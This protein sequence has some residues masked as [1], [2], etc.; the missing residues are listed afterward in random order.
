MN[1]SFFIEEHP[2][3]IDL[4]LAL[5]EMEELRQHIERYRREQDR[6]LSAAAWKLLFRVL[7]DE[8]GIDRRPNVRFT[9]LGKPLVDSTEG[10][11]I[12]LSHC[13][14]AV[15]CAV[16]PVPV[17][18]D[19]EST[20]AYDPQLLPLTMNVAEQ[21]DI[22]AAADPAHQFTRLW[23]MKESLLK[24]RGDGLTEALLPHVL[25]APQH[26]HFQTKTG[27]AYVCTFCHTTT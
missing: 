2:Q 22:L 25:D 14:E 5:D 3:H 7:R 17:G 12:S 19:I 9:A 10:L 20:S 23:T 15:A 11:Y 21:H 18:I 26:Y 8:Y 4:Q 13:T 24:L 1:C 27:E 16:G 6:R